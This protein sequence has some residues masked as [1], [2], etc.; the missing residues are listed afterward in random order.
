MIIGDD[1][2]TDMDFGSDASDDSLDLSDEDSDDDIANG[3]K[4][5]RGSKAAVR[6]VSAGFYPPHI[7]I[8]SV[9][10]IFRNVTEMCFCGTFYNVSLRLLYRYTNVIG[11]ELTVVVKGTSTREKCFTTIYQRFHTSWVNIGQLNFG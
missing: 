11:V 3:G 8:I 2:F 1:D 7:C 4:N 5:D 9:S 10:P 6:V